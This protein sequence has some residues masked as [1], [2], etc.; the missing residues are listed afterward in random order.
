MS[1]ELLLLASYA[2]L[3]LIYDVLELT[4]SIVEYRSI[5]DNPNYTYTKNNLHPREAYGYFERITSIYSRKH[6]RVGNLGY[7]IVLDPIVTLKV[8]KKTNK[9][10]LNPNQ[11]FLNPL[12]Y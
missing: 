1:V 6:S 8:F 12:K 10:F 2:L 4:S 7:V 11:V 3:F 5:L 9:E